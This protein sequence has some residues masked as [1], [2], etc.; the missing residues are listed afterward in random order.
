[1]LKKICFII[2]GVSYSGAEIVLNRYL[3]N[4]KFIEPFF[5]VIFENN[6]IDEKIK[7][8]YGK[9]NVY[10]L[11]IKYNKNI[12]RFFIPV[13]AGFIS[14]KIESILKYKKIDLIYV[15]N[16]T[17]G[18]LCYKY[19]LKAKLKSILHIHDMRMLYKRISHKYIINNY[20]KFY[21]KIITVSDAT[22]FSWEMLDIET[23]YN[24][25]DK[26]YFSN[27]IKNN[28]I[29]NIGFIGNL[30]YRKGADIFIKQIDNI[31]QRTNLNIFI[32]YKYYSKD[33]F[34][35]LNKY[36]NEK[37]VNILTNLNEYKMKK[38][39]D[40]LDILIVPSRLDPLPTVIME[41][42]ARKVLVLGNNTSGIPEMIPINDFILDMEC[43]GELIDKIIYIKNSTFEEIDNYREI[44]YNYTYKK[45]NNDSK[46]KK[47]NSIIE[48]I[49]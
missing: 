37:R 29:R 15:N 11:G 19:I 38:I 33:I 43:K 36:K 16:T 21:D 5:I 42:Q 1:M 9:S 14:N 26:N 31:L 2:S 17:E 48:R 40:N 39:Y 3:R 27:N 47:I 24:G 10:N 23:V 41:A 45:F 44:V 28:K 32:V 6:E 18:M 12:V 25:L 30:D 4:N 49:K 7:E 13:Y 8:L 22:K 35:L 34:N 20:F 46:I